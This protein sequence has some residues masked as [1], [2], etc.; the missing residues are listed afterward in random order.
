MSGEWDGVDRRKKPHDYELRGIIREELASIKEKQDEIEDKI[1]EWEL[2]AK[3][4]RMF[5]LGTVAFVGTLI[6]VYEWVKD[7]LK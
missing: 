1:N 2:V 6:G 7:H 5:I 3:W 4:F